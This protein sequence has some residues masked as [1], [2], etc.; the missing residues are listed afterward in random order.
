MW[1][2]SG[3]LSPHPSKA[4]KQLKAIYFLYSSSCL[5]ING[6]WKDIG[7]SSGNVARFIAWICET[8]ATF[9]C[10]L[11]VVV[12]G[13]LFVL[14]FPIQ[15]QVVE[16]TIRGLSALLLP[17]ASETMYHCTILKSKLSPKRKYLSTPQLN[18]HI[19]KSLSISWCRSP[20]CLK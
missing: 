10:F 5:Y 18:R 6:H 2:H 14:V 16:T 17:L 3:Y 20:F 1:K 8:P 9:F 11:F 13:L 7:P 15:N 4:L 12:F 19:V